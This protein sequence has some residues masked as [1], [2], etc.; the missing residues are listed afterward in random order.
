M[1][2]TAESLVFPFGEGTRQGDPSRIDLLG[3]KG[4]SLAEMSRAG[5][6]VPPGFTISTA[7]CAVVE[8]HGHWPA[9]LETQVRT[10]LYELEQAT[11][12]TFGQGPRPL[13]VAV[14]SGAAVSMPGMMDTILNCGLNPGVATCFPSEDCFWNEYAEHIRL[15][16]ASVAGVSVAAVSAANPQQRARQFLDTYER[17][18][19]RPF[20]RD[21]WEALQQSINAVFA[22]WHSDRA[23][24]YRQH[25]D[26]RGIVGTAVNVQAMFPSERSGV[27]FTVNPNDPAAG[28]MIL[29]ASWGLGEAVVS[30]A[31]TPDIYTL[32]ATTLQTRHELRGSRPGTDPALTLDQRREIAELGRR[33]ESHFGAPSDIEWGIAGGRVALLQ[34]RKIRGL[35]IV[36]DTERGR[37]DEIQRLKAIAIDEPT[38]WVVHNLSETLPAPTPLTWELIRWFMSARGGYGN[39]YRLLGHRPH[40]REPGHGFL[41]LISGRIYVD[42]R[43]AAEF[44]FGRLP[45]E[46][47]MDQ[48]VRDRTTLD[49]QPT[50]FNF[51][52]TD[53]LFFFRLPG[54]LWNMLR[55]SWRMQALKRDP[56]ERFLGTA[57]PKLEEFLNQSRQINLTSLSTAD[58][59][60]ELIRQ[61]DFV[62]GEFAG[63][64]LVPGFFG[65][66]A[67]DQ[68]RQL[69]IQLF[70]P[71]DGEQL[72]SQLT[73]GLQG[74]ITIEQNCQ[75][76][77]IAA[78]PAGEGH[79]YSRFLAKY[80]HR[81]INEMEL[82]QPRWRE[83]PQFVDRMIERF[84]G[85]AT[86]S[87]RERHEQQVI[88]RRRAEESLPARLAAAGGSS[89]R[90]R[91]EH[92]MR[93]AQQL[94]PY[95]ELGKFHLMRGYEA[96]RQV[97]VELGRR[98]DLGRDVFFLRLEEL[99]QFEH[100]PAAVIQRIAERK[101][102]WRSQQKLKLPDLVDS[103]QL[104][105]FG[106][107][108]R[109]V[110]SGDHE[111]I[112]CRPI[113][114][115]VARGS[116]RIV[117]DPNTVT[118]LGRDYILVC[119]STDPGWTP[120]FVNARGLIVERGG[121][122]SH[123]AIVAR[124][125]GIPAVVLESATQLIAEGALLDLDAV[126]GT[127]LVQHATGASV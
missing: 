49:R 90:E 19:G 75:L 38:V 42:P 21:P 81:A 88:I 100:D 62:L 110:A 63:E 120:L 92:S 5:F 124:D 99:T 126:H 34:T 112:A 47:D 69:L 3:G 67:H 82:S 84:R 50:R 18:S 20:P 52:R 104:A 96:L 118:E 86:G 85:T 39:L 60:R 44:H 87:P 35:E 65:G 9:G 26:L 89:L 8:Q 58:M 57:L 94:L 115:G 109:V 74:D 25:H 17:Q 15:F 79:D 31:V 102:R 107:V 46:Y 4:A 111:P 6:P 106:T 59:V 80:G 127:I 51:D 28:E 14:R 71:D 23:R 93:Q 91:I 77:E 103:R 32:D 101:L 76:F 56:V 33:I 108:R 40:E 98:W 1:N 29:E 12:R 125:F 2:T 117:L 30:G 73:T 122:L 78:K 43:R 48:V 68:L 121:V 41:E 24:A 95:R 27:L 11:G 36:A 70:G 54:L 83:D 61:R 66:L 45:F 16:A 113:A 64:S 105:E 123:G 22:S 37:L 53:S 72:A 116:A 13:F 119:P 55:G 97:L 10:A 7:C 114:S